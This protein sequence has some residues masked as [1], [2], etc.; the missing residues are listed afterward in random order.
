MSVLRAFKAYRP[1]K[2][3]A[4]KV[5]ALPYDVMNSKEAAEMVKG[6]PY[7]FLHI[8]KAEI[9]LPEDT[10]IYDEAV[11]QKANDNLE[12][13]IKKG[14]FVQDLKPCL[15]IYAQTRNGKT[16]TGI[17]GCTA[18]DDYINNVIK[19]HELT[20]A[21]KESNRIHHFDTLDTNTLPIFLPYRKNYSFHNLI[22]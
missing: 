15:Y 4:D 19:K 7:S 10:Y 22:N 13:A 6:N 16:Q 3:L 14:V 2:E 11:Y 20:R 9:D 17:V 1:T 21:D 5:A 18:I 8:D 12:N